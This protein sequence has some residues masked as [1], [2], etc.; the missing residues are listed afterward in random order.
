MATWLFRP[1]RTALLAGS[2]ALTF[3]VMSTTATGQDHGSDHGSSS[4]HS[5]GG[6]RGPKYMGGG[7][8]ESH[9]HET[10]AA[11]SHRGSSS[12]GGSKHAEDKIFHGHEDHD[13]EGEG[14]GTEGHDHDAPVDG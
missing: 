3:A 5:D 4:S 9:S 7:K 11:G 10:H 13:L 8:G 1:A 2:L 14:S 12:R 6:K